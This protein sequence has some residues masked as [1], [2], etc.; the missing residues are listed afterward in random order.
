[1]DLLL[2]DLVGKYPVIAT[3]IAIVGILRIV[4][5]PLV[6]IMENVAAATETKADDVV[7]E[8][9]KTSAIYKGLVWLI[10]YVASVKLPK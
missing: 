6:S 1:M 7:V 4:I 3:V 10:D 5:K 9:V 8:K 2:L